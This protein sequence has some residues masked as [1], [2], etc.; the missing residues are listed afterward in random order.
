MVDVPG[1]DVYI[2][3]ACERFEFAHGVVGG[4]EP[5]SWWKLFLNESLTV[6]LSR[7]VNLSADEV[8]DGVIAHLRRHYP[9]MCR[10]WFDA[11]EPISLD[12]GT[13]K[14]L[15]NEPVQLKYLR[16]TCIDYFNEAAAAVSGHLLA[17]N[18]LSEEEARA[19]ATSANGRSRYS[20][21]LAGGASDEMVLSPDYTFD[22]F[23]VGP[24]NRL[25]HAAAIAVAAKPGEAYNPFFI[26]SGVG[27]GKTHLLQ[28]IAQQLLRNRRETNIYYIPCEEFV[29]QFLDHVAK[30]E[31]AD[32]RHR[33]REVE[34]LMID[35][36]HYLAERDRI[37]EEFFHTFNTLH[38]AGRQIILSSDASPNEIPDLEERL[39]SRFSCGLVVR[40]E[41]PCYETRMAILKKKAQLRNLNLPDDVI[42]LIASSL[43][44][45]IR[46]LEGAI[47]KLHMLA[48]VNGIPVDLDMTREAIGD[49]CATNGTQMPTIQTITDV[50]VDYYNVKRS[51]LLSKKRHKSIAL[52]RQVCMALA[53]DLTRFSLQEIGGFFGGRDHTTVLHAV[54]S[55]R[56]R[57]I[58]DDNLDSD[59]TRLEQLL[60]TGAA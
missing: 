47:T 1:F 51:D 55:I 17:V 53:R 35:D 32:F 31:M 38:Q 36:I 43:E 23:I 52:P 22:N 34:V 60:T 44:N 16:R 5:L 26:H 20:H 59:V 11:I 29:N 24:G 19:E 3:G 7:M 4:P 30:G 14:L 58:I 25:A 50:V 15:V 56:D 42:S 39:V 33:Y 27:L 12:G 28:A 10:H 45:N 18:F 41:K 49:R 9:E 21:S 57:R 54:K 6:S 46:E 40:I 2:D 13:L 37:Q 8:R 48:K